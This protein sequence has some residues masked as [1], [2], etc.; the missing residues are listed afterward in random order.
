MRSVEAAGFAQN[1][2]EWFIAK[3]DVYGAKFREKLLTP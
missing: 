1:P 2:S 3:H